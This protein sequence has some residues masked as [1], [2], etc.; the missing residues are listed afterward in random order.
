MIETLEILTVKKEIL[1]QVPPFSEYKAVITDIEET[2]F[3]IGLPR[4]EGQVLV[5]QKDQEIQIRVPM[6]YG[7]YSADSKVV[8]IGHDSQRF[9]GLLIPERF[10]MLKARQFMR[11]EH[12][13]HV[14]FS[15]G[16]DTAQT[17]M[18]NF[19]EGGCMVYVTPA[20]EKMLQAANDF[21]VSFQVNGEL[22]TTT[23]RLAWRKNTDNVPYAGFKFTNLL[24]AQRQRL[25][26]LAALFSK[27]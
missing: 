5:L 12:A 11:V 23:A 17:A 22:I 8:A 26:D 10:Q 9:Y 27:D 19:S 4:Q 3:W 7:L 14:L 18:L 16:N 24:P 20:L 13:T 6:R 25:A 2:L 1:I 15:S 21:S